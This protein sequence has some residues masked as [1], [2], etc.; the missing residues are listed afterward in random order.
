MC[1]E[2]LELAEQGDG[3]PPSAAWRCAA[4]EAHAVYLELFLL[5]S[6]KPAVSVGG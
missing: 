4:L 3:S 1:A 5:R 6:P 2:L